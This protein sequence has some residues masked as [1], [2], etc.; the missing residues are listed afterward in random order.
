MFAPCAGARPAGVACNEQTVAK[1]LESGWANVLSNYGGINDSQAV[2][3]ASRYTRGWSV[4]RGLREQQLHAQQPDRLN[5]HD[6]QP[7]TFG[8]DFDAFADRLD[9]HDCADLDGRDARSERA[10]DA[11]G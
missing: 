4:H 5:P 10:E 6:D 2:H 3:M 8:D 11:R 1:P 9:A 7:S